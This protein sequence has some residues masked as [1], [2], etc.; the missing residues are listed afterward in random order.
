M[1]YNI[2]IKHC[3]LWYRGCVLLDIVSVRRIVRSKHLRDETEAREQ[4]RE[5]KR[6]NRRRSMADDE[7]SFIKITT[8]SANLYIRCGFCWKCAYITICEFGDLSRRANIINT[9]VHVYVCVWRVFELRELYKYYT[10]RFHLNKDYK[11]R[12]HR[13]ERERKREAESTLHTR[14]YVCVCAV[15]VHRNLYSTLKFYK[16][17][18][19][20]GHSALSSSA[21]VASSGR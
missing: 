6:R 3:K 19:F 14:I 1:I 2:V 9:M 5:K 10:L 21:L 17:F 12:A 20:Y 8:T 18:Q 16:N 4:K 13:Q 7:S 15:Y 11:L